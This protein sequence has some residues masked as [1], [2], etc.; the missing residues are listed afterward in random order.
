M[1]A[2]IEVH[3]LIAFE[4]F[5]GTFALKEVPSSHQHV[6]H[7]SSRKDVALAR[8]LLPAGQRQHLGG[9]VTRRAALIVHVVLVILV[10]SQPEI[11]DYWLNSFPLFQHQVLKFDIPVDDPVGL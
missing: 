11:H 2:D 3:G 10:N 9:K 6:H 4:H 5:L 1:A 7:H 8:Q